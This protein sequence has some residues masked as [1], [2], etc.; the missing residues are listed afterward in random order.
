MI[1]VVANSSGWNQVNDEDGL[2]RGEAELDRAL[3]KYPCVTICPY[4]TRG[5]NSRTIYNGALMNHPAVIVGN[6]IKDNPFYS[7]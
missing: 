3:I 1:R 7:R 5:L 6:S 4:R 2:I